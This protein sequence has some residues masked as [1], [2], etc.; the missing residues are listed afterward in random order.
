MKKLS[1]LLIGLLL[2]PSLF[3]TSCDKG[4]EPLVNTTPPFTLMKDYVINN[5]Y[6]IDKILMSP[7]GANFVAGA[8]AEADLTAFLNKYYIID[9]RS[10]ADFAKGHIQGAKNVP[11]A[12]ILA[13]G[14]A[15]GTKPVL[16]VCYTGQTACYATALMRMYG[17]RNTQALKWGMS[18]WNPTT[19]GSWN[20]KIGAN[21]ADGH[22]NWTYDAAATNQVFT[23][24]EIST[25]STDGAAIFK[26]RIETVVQEG[27]KTVAGTDVL[28]T[29][30][31][32]FVNNYFNPT[33]FA[34]FG[35]IKGA[36]RIL[37]VKLSDNSYLNL[38]PS[39]GAKVVNYCYT[40]QTSAVLTAC[41]R[42]LGYDAYS[43]TFG[44]NGLYNT[45]TA[46]AANQ[47]GVGSSNPK[48]LP[49]VTN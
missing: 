47:W 22:A 13:E 4:D 24:P 43:M 32:Y 38:D 18:G 42:V 23:N 17:F 8:P 5:N 11:F 48:N 49:L 31:N 27:F 19:A 40:G 39:P 20:S 44:V 29:P 26:S 3:L 30:T 15:A 36:Y 28:N 45:N 2:V 46:W 25:L 37:P 9:I 10:A 6:D 1:L 14:A 21:V 16:V 41:L 35:H 12:N 34:S 33:D 7:D